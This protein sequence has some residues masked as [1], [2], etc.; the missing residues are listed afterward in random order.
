[1]IQLI[2][3]ILPLAFKVIEFFMKKSEADDAAKK[4]W[5]EFI[6][7]ME[8][9]NTHSSVRLRKS[10]QNQLVRIKKMKEDMENK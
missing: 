1:M 3:A 7:E 5:F 8:K 9:T 2:I 10:Y 6:E 4:K